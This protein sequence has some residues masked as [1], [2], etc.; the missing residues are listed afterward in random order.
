MEPLIGEEIL[1]ME[2]ALGEN[3]APLLGFSK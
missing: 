3:Y 1:A 2:E